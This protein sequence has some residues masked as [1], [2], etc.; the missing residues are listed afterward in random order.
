M[1]VVVRRAL[2]ALRWV[3]VGAVAIALIGGGVALASLG[4][5]GRAGAAPAANPSITQDQAKAKALEAVP[6]ATVQN[7]DLD[8]DRG[9]TVWEVDVIGTDRV[10][11]E[12]KVD[13]NSGAVLS[14]DRDD[15]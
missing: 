7:A 1:A 15:D 11:Y 4:T 5:E 14:T 12:V 6:G 3:L 9:A 10:E 2:G 8:T 13:A